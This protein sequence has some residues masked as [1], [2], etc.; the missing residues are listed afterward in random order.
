MRNL[1]DQ[2]EWGLDANLYYLSL[3][4]SL[5]LPDICGAMDSEDGQASRDR[6]VA[7]FNKYVQPLF[8]GTLKGIIVQT[9]SIETEAARTWLT[10]DAC[11]RLRCFL[12]H[13][14]SP[15]QPAIPFSRIAFVVSEAGT[16]V[17]HRA[18]LN[19]VLFVD[20]SFFCKK[21]VEGVR[22]W[23]REVEYTVRFRQNYERLIKLHSDGISFLVGG[24]GVV[25]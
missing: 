21:I 3:F 14:E 2:I 18:L 15:E 25:D 8:E 20:L 13:E 12:L 1:L 24:V 10:G 22:T 7:W 16:S 17:V 19:D 5:A 4:A 11:Y 9:P 23:L 6:Y